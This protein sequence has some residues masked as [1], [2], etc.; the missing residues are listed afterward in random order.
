[1]QLLENGDLRIA[2]KEEGAELC[3]LYSKEH[4]LEFLWQADR[5]FWG[6]HAPVLF[7][8]VGKLKNNTYSYK[9]KSYTLPQH[10]FA[11]DRSFVLNEQ[12]DNSLSYMLSYDDESLKVYPFKFRLYITY[13]LQESRLKVTY[14]VENGGDEEMYFSIG[15]HPAFNCPLMDGENYSD[16]YLE[17]EWY[18]KIE[19]I[20]IEQ[21]YLSDRKEQ[22]LNYSRKIP[23]HSQLFA[24]DA[25]IFSGLRFGVKMNFAGFPYLGIWARPGADF[26]CIEPWYGI[27]DTLESSGELQHK[28]GIQ[29]LQAGGSFECSYTMQP[30]SIH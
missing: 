20:F 3:S 18:E 10:G 9:G 29:M 12:T 5:A 8:I 14:R 13:T 15:A 25:L 26:I 4:E 1:M 16:Y 21:G 6:R 23:L 11:R 7:P 17:F 2:V 22:V 27:T 30:F 28:E 24:D 19:R